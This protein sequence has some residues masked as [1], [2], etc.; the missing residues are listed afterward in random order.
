MERT[1]FYLK[2]ELARELGISLKTLLKRV[3]IQ[4]DEELKAYYR[5]QRLFYAIEKQYILD[6][7]QHGH[8]SILS[9]GGVN[10]HDSRFAF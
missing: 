8:T 7:I 9:A 5:S 1:Q 2:E 4:N 6:H 3:N 10:C